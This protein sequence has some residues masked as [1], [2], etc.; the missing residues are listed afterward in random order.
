MTYLQETIHSLG[1]NIGSV[2]RVFKW[3]PKK[4]KS[5]L[6]SLVESN[7]TLKK[8]PSQDS[9]SDIEWDLDECYKAIRDSA[10]HQWDDFA[11]G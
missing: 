11:G 2:L 1:Q 5:N 10:D 3:H 9:N 7:K 4:Q 6:T 8:T